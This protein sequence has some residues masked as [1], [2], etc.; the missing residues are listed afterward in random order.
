MSKKG[1]DEKQPETVSRLEDVAQIP[2]EHL[3]GKTELV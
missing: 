3:H 2:K 1:I